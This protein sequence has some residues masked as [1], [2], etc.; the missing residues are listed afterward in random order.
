MNITLEKID[1]T[2]SKI[3]VNVDENDYKEKVKKQLKEIGAK[4]QLPGFRKG[5]VPMDQL[6][7]RFGKGVKS[8]VINDAVYQEVFKYIQDNNLKV[9]GQPLPVEVKEISMDQKDYT[10]EYEIG[11][12]PDL[13]FELSK[14]ITIP[15]Y[16][17]KIDDEMVAKQSDS[18][19]E[20]FG[21]Q[22]PG[23]EVDAKAV[24]KGAIMQ[25]NEDGTVRE[26][27][28]AIQ[29]MDGIVAPFLF[30]SE[31]EKAKFM[32]KK[33]QDKVV[34]NPWDTCNGNAAELSSMLH[35]DK[36]RVADLHDNFEFVISEI[37]VNKPAEMNEEF[38]KEAFGSEVTTEEQYFDAVR[39]LINRQLQ[40]NSQALFAR[41][42]RN[43]LVEMFGNVELP[44]EFLKKWLVARNE[45]LTTEQVEKD[46]DNI[47]ADVKWQLIKE[48]IAAKTDLKI[49]NEDL[50]AYARMLARQQFAQYGMN[51]V[52]NETLDSFAERILNDKNYRSQIIETV[53]DNKLFANIHAAVNAPVEEVSLDKFREIA[54]AAQ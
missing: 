46:L 42:A 8:D 13:N 2:T 7:R 45:G 27:E 19:R 29:V 32:G 17:I 24:I 25:L 14:D 40:P 38:F 11:I 15:Y 12:G 35:V 33:V 4:N 51:N 5:H 9:L 44:V 16:S 39:A 48:H 26:G 20:R 54:E 36:E 6:I 50:K 18:I 28:D 30:K 21:A 3:I 43:K 37:I 10:F 23:E 52:D 41:D 53:G 22:L 34:F 49:E 31:D 1:N 47:L